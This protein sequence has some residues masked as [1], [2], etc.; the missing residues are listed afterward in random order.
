MSAAEDA[1]RAVADL[2]PAQL[3]EVAMCFWVK[4]PTSFFQAIEAATT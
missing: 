1:R 4:D 3:R 2:T